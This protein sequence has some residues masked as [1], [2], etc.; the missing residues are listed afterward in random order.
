MS[1]SIDPPH[2]VLLD[3]MQWIAAIYLWRAHRLMGEL[4]HD[5]VAT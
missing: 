3:A 1:I 5:H 2:Y 4:W